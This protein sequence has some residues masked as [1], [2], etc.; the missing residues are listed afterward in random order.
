M[1]HIY[2]GTPE[3]SVYG[4]DS[5]FY[6]E[7]CNEWFED[8][9]V[10]RMILDI[11]KTEV[12][13]NYA[14]N[15]PVLGIIPSEY[16]SGGVKG[17]IVLLKEDDIRIHGST[18]GDNCGTWLLRLGSIKDIY[19][20]LSHLLDFRKDKINDIDFDLEIYVDNDNTILHSY[21]EYVFKNIEYNYR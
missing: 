8:D 1:L 9:V 20:S 14:F 11:D 19:I 3:D 12:L 5:Y 21:K 6:V 18:F 2:F 13:S 17:L 16:L 15:S 10:K 7:S 4:I